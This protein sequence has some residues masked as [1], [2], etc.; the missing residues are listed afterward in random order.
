MQFLI[1]A[2]DAKDEGALERRMAARD[3]HLAS[4]AAYKAKGHM[5]IGAALLDDAGKMIGSTL[6]VEFDNAA[7]CEAWLHADPYV[8]GKVWQ[9]ISV[10]PCKI[11]PSFVAKA[12]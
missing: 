6:I 5:H 9:D 12:A 1:V 7:E 10:T 11:A 4:I 3:A 2:Y 8:T